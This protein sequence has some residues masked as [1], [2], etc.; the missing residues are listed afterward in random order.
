MAKTTKTIKTTKQ[1]KTIK[2]TA[3]ELLKFLG[4]EG[5]IEVSEDKENE[6]HLVQIETD[7]PGILI[8]Y[9]GEAISALQVILGIMVHKKLDEWLRVVVNVGDYRQKRE[10]TLN[11]MALNAAQ[12]AHFS[13]QPVVLDSLTASERRIVHM[14]LSE[15]S[16]VETYSEGEGRERKLVIKPR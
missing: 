3:K 1:I 14:A 11:R 6:A 16:D 7:N 12:K 2:D 15:N 9:H 4:F 13:G 10:E 8:G 5:P